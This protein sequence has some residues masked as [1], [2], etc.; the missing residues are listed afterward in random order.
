MDKKIINHVEILKIK[1]VL[2]IYQGY[3]IRFYFV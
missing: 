3:I 1:H 2:K